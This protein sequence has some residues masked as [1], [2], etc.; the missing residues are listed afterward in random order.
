Y[1]T[2]LLLPAFF[3]LVFSYTRSGYLALLV[4]MCLVL[5]IFVKKSRWPLIL[6]P[7]ASFIPLALLLPQRLGAHA[8]AGDGRWDLWKFGWEVFCSKPWF[9]A[10]FGEYNRAFRALGFVPTLDEITISHPHNIYLQFLCESGIV[11]TFFI[12]IF[13]LGFLYWGYRRVRQ[14]L[15]QAQAAHA[16][17]A[18]YHWRLATFFWAAWGAYLANGIFGHDFFRLWW[19]SLS[20]TLL[21]LMIGACC[22]APDLDKNIENNILE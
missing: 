15:E 11:G 3:L 1:S 19:F 6:L 7:L 12:L 16:R 20:M 18:I 4:G 5:F 13:L 2:L 14:G 9:G 8:L 22:N 17:Q 21:G 10:G